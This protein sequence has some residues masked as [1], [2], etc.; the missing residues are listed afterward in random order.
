MLSAY[1]KANIV[2]SVQYGLMFSF[3]FNGGY[4]NHD[5]IHIFKSACFTGLLYYAL[6]TIFTVIYDK[7]KTKDLNNG[8]FVEPVQTRTISTDLSVSDAFDRCLEK[9]NNLKAN[10]VESNR[11]ILQISSIVNKKWYNPGERL[12]I[13]IHR[14]ANNK[15]NIIINA[16]PL[17]KT[18]TVDFGI[19]WKNAEM[20]CQLF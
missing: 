5:L 17:D 14:D 7:I 13:K 9:L 20:I 1:F 15:T 11:S 19:S 16:S 8:K 4:M 18:V 2:K 3:I 10:I 6:T 12:D